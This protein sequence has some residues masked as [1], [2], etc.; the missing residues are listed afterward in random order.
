MVEQVVDW[1]FE[2]MVMKFVDLDFEIEKIWLVEEG[3]IV[4]EKKD[5]VVGIEDIK[6]IFHK[7]F[8]NLMPRM[9]FE[10]VGAKVTKA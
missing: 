8:S 3:N 9:D 5:K 2:E 1:F 10:V 6:D 4:V 7:D